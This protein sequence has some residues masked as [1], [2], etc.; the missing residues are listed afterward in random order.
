MTIMFIIIIIIVII[1]AAAVVEIIRERENKM[2]ESITRT[3]WLGKQEWFWI[4]LN[5]TALEIKCY[6]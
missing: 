1:Y 2:H 6:L 4:I 3:R 5:E